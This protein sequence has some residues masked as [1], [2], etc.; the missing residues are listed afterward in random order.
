M[1]DQPLIE[2]FLGKLNDRIFEFELLFR[3][4]KVHQVFKSPP[5]NYR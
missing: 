1:F 2:F 3:P 5:Q 4:R